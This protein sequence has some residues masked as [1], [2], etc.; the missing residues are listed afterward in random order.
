MQHQWHVQ[1]GNNGVLYAYAKSPTGSLHR[2]IMNCQRYNGILIDHV[3]RNGLDCRKENLRRSNT[4]LNSMNAVKRKGP[5]NILLSGGF[6]G[7]RS[8]E[9]DI[10]EFD[11]RTRK[12]PGILRL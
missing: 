12:T 11:G 6:L 8:E 9:M 4:T 1:E 7:F 2:F 10:A 3:S 5:T